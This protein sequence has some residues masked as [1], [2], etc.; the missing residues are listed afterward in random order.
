MAIMKFAPAIFCLMF[1]W[2]SN[3]QCG[4]LHP[5]WCSFIA[6]LCKKFEENPSSSTQM[7][8]HHEVSPNHPYFHLLPPVLI[9][10]PVEQF[11]EVFP[12]GFT[13]PKCDSG[14]SSILYGYDWM[15]GVESER[16]EP[17]KIHGRDGIVLLVGR[18]Y[19]C[20][21]KSH[22]VVGYH[23]GI[24]RQINAPTLIPFRL[25]SRTGFTSSLTNY[26][27]TMVVSGVSVSTIESNLV[28]TTVTQYS[29][30]RMRFFELQGLSSTPSSDFPSYEQWTSLLPAAAP[31]RHAISACFLSSFWE[32]HSLFDKHM[33]CTTTT[34]EDSWLSCDHTFAS[35]GEY[36]L[37]SHDITC[38]FNF[39]HMH[40]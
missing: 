14:S 9:W 3:A 35:A 26:I 12:N 22:E 23:P 34:D 27:V 11:K 2:M 16:T 5:Q 36:I 32:I 1:L 10:S 7:Y 21:K 38:I 15:T 29:M 17:R 25:W 33:Q 37:Y 20:F 30:K 13:C 31:S 28:L 6:D 8:L 18:R 4:R 40:V 24:L 39:L 19:K